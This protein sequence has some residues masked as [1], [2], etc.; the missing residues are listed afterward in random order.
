LGLIYFLS[1]K[2]FDPDTGKIYKYSDSDGKLMQIWVLEELGK[3]LKKAEKP[4]SFF[5]R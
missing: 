1:A 2:F 5:E 4:G 3:D